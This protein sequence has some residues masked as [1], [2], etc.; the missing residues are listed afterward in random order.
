[1]RQAREIARLSQADVAHHLHV[2]RQAISS[3]EAGRTEPSLGT[4]REMA[5]VYG[6]PTDLILNGLLCVPIEMLEEIPAG[7]CEYLDRARA[8]YQTVVS[9]LGRQGHD[10]GFT[11][12]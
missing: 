7:A 3:W 12:L 5:M 9:A 2:T 11:P 10:S 1:M 4:F 6:V 8:R